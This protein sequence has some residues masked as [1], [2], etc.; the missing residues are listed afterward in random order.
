M[1]FELH[2][3]CK[4]NMPRRND[5]LA[6]NDT[7]IDM[8]VN[9]SFLNELY[10]K[11]HPE[12]PIIEELVAT[13]VK[14]WFK[15]CVKIDLP[16]TDNELLKLNYWGPIVEVTTFPCYFV[17]GYNFD[18]ETDSVGRLTMNCVRGMKVHPRH[19]LVDV[20][21]KKVYQ[22]N[23][24]FILAQQVV[25]VY[26]TEYPSLKMDKVD[27]MVVCKTKARRV[28]DNF[29]WTEVAFQDDEAIPTPQVLTDNHNYELHDPIGIQ[30]VVDL[31]IANKQGAGTSRAANGESDDEDDEDSFDKNYETEEYNNYD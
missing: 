18:I 31:S 28:I 21:F 5:D 17:N 20:N 24:P 3:L 9:M 27:W 11:Y 19:H 6:M 8:Y 12:D 16:Y 13:Q 4:R 25:Q 1:Y 10:E 23:E 29:R 14:D 26:Y 22:K 15:R 7:R 2:V 30:L